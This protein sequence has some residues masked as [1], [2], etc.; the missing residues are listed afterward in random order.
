MRADD[1]GAVWRNQPEE[2]AAVNLQN[3][4]HR[5]TQEL[6]AATRSEIL[7]SVAAALLFVGV[8]ALRL[9]LTQQPALQIGIGAA[10]AWALITVYRL[11]NRIRRREPEDA[12]DFA[13]TGVEHY[14][15]ELQRR[16]D[17]LGNTWLWQGPLVLAC[18]IFILIF[19]GK[20]PDPKR[21]QNVL[22]LVLL[23]AAWVTMGVRS[24]RR[25]ARELQKEIDEIDAL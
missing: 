19:A 17:H 20:A 11:R 7:I 3:L 24:R 6:R 16:R 12:D 1:P 5:R 4:I 13:A 9:P 10:I 15:R 22:P 25:K 18:S 2:K 8:L 14:R 23:V 21:L